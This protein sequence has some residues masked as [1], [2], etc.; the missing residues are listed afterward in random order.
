MARGRKKATKIIITSNDKAFFQCV[1]KSGRTS[2]ELA[3][4]YFKIKPARISKMIKAGYLKTEP[5]IIQKKAAY[6]LRLTD[7]AKKYIRDNIATVRSF[8]QASKQGTAHDLYVF[9]ELAKKPKRLQDMALVGNDIVNFFGKDE[10]SSPPD[11]FF[12]ATTIENK[13]GEI[14][15]HPPQAIEVITRTYKPQHI[16]DKI[17]YCQ[18]RMNLPKGAIKFVKAA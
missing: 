15:Y 3:D 18:Y 7:F 9:E 6:C 4:K 11:I 17:N 1:A 5:I 13:L 16:E 12:P 14:H 10:A 2:N 8:Y